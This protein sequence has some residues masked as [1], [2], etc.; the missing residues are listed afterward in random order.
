[1]E[2]LLLGVLALGDVGLRAGQ[3]VRLARA[4]AHRCAA[5]Q[6]PAP[7]PVGVA[8]TVLHFEER[9]APLE[10][11]PQIAED[12]LAVVGVHAVEPGVGVVADLALARPE[13]RLPARGKEDLVA[14]QVPVPQP[15]VGALRGQGISL[16]A[17]AHGPFHAFSF[18]DVEDGPDHR[19]AP[20]VDGARAVH[21]DVDGRAVLAPSAEGVVDALQLSL[22]AQPQVLADDGQVLGP[23]QLHHRLDVLHLR[24]RVAEDLGELGVHVDELVVLDDVAADDGLLDQ[25][26]ELVL[27][28]LERLRGLAPLGDVARDSL[29]FHGTVAAAADGPRGQLERD[30]MPVLVDDLHLEELPLAGELALDDGLDLLDVF[31]R[32][33]VPDAQPQALFARVARDALPG[34]V[35]PGEAALEVVRINDVAGVL[36]QVA[37]VRLRLAGRIRAGLRHFLHHSSP[38]LLLPGCRWNAKR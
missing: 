36:D 7:A 35:H 30:A 12:P 25:P 6:H 24:L 10:V 31:G 11:Q 33:D 27:A 28:R 14:A 1:M 34:L 17:L 4:V 37:I 23:G 9:R 2:Q 38:S 13:L 15:V 16:L 26:A 21:L 22:H 5:H 29:H 3:P 32:E 19:V 18:G 8:H 20:L